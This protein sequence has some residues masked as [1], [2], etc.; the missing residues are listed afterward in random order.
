M[1]RNW[2]S[3]TWSKACGRATVE[4]D[5]MRTR[6][7]Y[8]SPLTHS[9]SGVTQEPLRGSFIW[10]C[11]APEMPVSTENSGSMQKSSDLSVRPWC[12]GHSRI[13]LGASFMA[14]WSVLQS[15]GIGTRGQE[16]AAAGGEAIFNVAVGKQV[17]ATVTRSFGPRAAR[18]QQRWYRRPSGQRSRMHRSLR[19]RVPLPR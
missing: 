5:Q 16:I 17:E 10:L 3:G 19:H 1:L 9:T 7:L 15:R 2:S 6:F 12:R 13:H 8:R 18:L 4:L 11:G 14:R